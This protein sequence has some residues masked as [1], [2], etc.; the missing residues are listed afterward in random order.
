MGAV[1]GSISMAI[2]LLATSNLY[3]LTHRR[4]MPG[5]SPVNE[6]SASDAVLLER[7]GAVAII[8][9]NRPHKR[10]ALAVELY[11]LLSKTVNDLQDDPSVRAIVLC[12]G[13]HFCV[14]G[15][16]GSFDVP[17]LELRTAMQVGQRIV[18][19]LIGGRLP[20]VAAVEG[21]AYGAG[22]SLALACD[23]VVAD[24]SATF[25]AAFGRVALMPDYGLLW[26][27]PQRVGIVKARE[28]VMFCEVLSATQ[29]HELGLVD[30]LVAPGT[31]LE[32]AVGLAERLA[33]APPGAIATTKS[34][35]A[36]GPL[37][38]DILLAWEADTQTLLIGSD[39][40]KEGIQAFRQ[41]RNPEFKG[42]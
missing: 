28:M 42:R 39:D 18:R 33:A 8:T 4:Q 3:Y 30:R 2:Y 23:F 38:L 20:A 16:L 14:G 1:I 40:A 13:R 9:M 11:S 10:N 41:R 36:R 6:T 24:D 29:A 15:D 34:V 7:R 32:S 22:F 19:A 17:T 31:V 27:L 5:D 25:C 12:G 26:T 37:T 35:L 21:N